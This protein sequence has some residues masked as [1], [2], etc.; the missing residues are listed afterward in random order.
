MSDEEADES[1]DGC[2]SYQPP[3]FYFAPESVRLPARPIS[4]LENFESTFDAG[5]GRAL[6]AHNFSSTSQHHACAYTHHSL[7]CAR[8][9]GHT[10]K[11]LLCEAFSESFFRPRRN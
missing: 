2:H 10:H 8:T 6:H 11:A 9:K 5:R 1:L 4:R 3:E 7:R